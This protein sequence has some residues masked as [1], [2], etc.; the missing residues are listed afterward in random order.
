MIIANHYRSYIRNKKNTCIII[1]KYNYAYYKTEGT[2][3]KKNRIITIL[4]N[5]VI[6]N[7]NNLYKIL[8]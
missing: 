6:I 5:Q 4:L 7:N 8:D 1:I 2:V 3:F